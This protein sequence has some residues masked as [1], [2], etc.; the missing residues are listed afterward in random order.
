MQRG[1]ASLKKKV[2]SGFCPIEIKRGDLVVE[3]QVIDKREGC[4][5]TRNVR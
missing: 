1:V 4:H 3:P 5:G 2:F